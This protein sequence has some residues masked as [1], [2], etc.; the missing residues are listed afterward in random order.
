MSKSKFSLLEVE[1]VAV[2]EILR[3]VKD[4]EIETTDA[5][6]QLSE[7]LL[8]YCSF[9]MLRIVS[10]VAEAADSSLFDLLGRLLFDVDGVNGNEESM[11]AHRA[12]AA[13]VQWRL[14]LHRCESEDSGRCEMVASFLQTVNE[15]SESDLDL[16]ATVAFLLQGSPHCLKLFKQ[17]LKYAFDSDTI[18]HTC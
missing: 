5:H 10:F 3:K 15:L 16:V 18:S 9:D 8:A 6:E 2:I 13:A 14:R 17:H 11:A 1:A 12:E 7:T 4:R